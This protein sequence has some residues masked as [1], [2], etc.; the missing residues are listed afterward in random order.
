MIFIETKRL[1]LRN[2]Q[3]GDFADI[4]AYFS[5][6]EVSRYEDFYP[7]T[8]A[9]IADLLSE[10]IPLDNRLVA[11]RKSDKT[12][13]GSIGYWVDNEGHH[14]IDY[15]FH[16]DYCGNGYATEAAQALVQHLF[17]TTNICAV[18]ADCD[19]QNTASWK[20]LERIGFQRL[21]MLENQCYKHDSAGNP[22]LIR[23]YLLKKNAAILSIEKTGAKYS[24]MHTAAQ[25]IIAALR[26][27][28]GAATRQ[29]FLPFNIK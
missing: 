28:A 7:M 29:I 15:D 24:N 5:N 23:N 18:Y 1:I 17:E 4:R 12:V 20:L 21:R 11:E 13:I 3:T 22:I 25:I 14:C 26:R 10:W 16:P 27:A 9:Q 19:I 2:Y 6:E 8:D